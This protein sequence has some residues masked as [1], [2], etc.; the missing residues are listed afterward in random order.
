MLHDLIELREPDVQDKEHLL[1]GFYENICVEFELQNV[2]LCTILSIHIL[3]EM[4]GSEMPFITTSFRNEDLSM[5]DAV[6]DDNN[7]DDAVGYERI[8]P[9]FCV[10]REMLLKLF[11]N[12]N[13]S[14][15]VE[16]LQ[17][18]LY[19]WI[20]N[21]TSL[22]YEPLLV[23]FLHRQMH[24]VCFLHF[25]F[26]TTVEVSLEVLVVLIN[27]MKQLGAIVPFATCRRMII[28]TKR[29]HSKD[30]MRYCGFLANTIRE[31][32]LLQH[33]HFAPILFVHRCLI[34]VDPFNYGSI[35]VVNE[36]SILQGKLLEEDSNRLERPTPRMFWDLAAHF[37]AELA[38]K[39]HSIM[40]QLLESLYGGSLVCVDSAEEKK[41]NSAPFSERLSDLRQEL[42]SLVNNCADSYHVTGVPAHPGR[43]TESYQ[44]IV[45]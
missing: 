9:A 26:Q 31:N 35:P 3:S 7:A 10:L 17:N 8:L 19:R 34:F 44:P 40:Q 11:T 39:W 20:R 6:V 42:Y 2:A 45:L 28:A 37:T 15:T 16:V 32:E 43:L 18:H 25:F 14:S 21:E 4:E 36:T 23:R 12:E 30:A 27:S 13:K 29:G 38:S 33:L 22:L 1:P 41:C 5:N 24:K